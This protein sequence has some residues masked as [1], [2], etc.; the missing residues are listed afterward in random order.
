MFCPQC[1]QAQV[2]AE[3]KFCSRCGFPLSGVKKLI[4]HGSDL[5]VSADAPGQSAAA[6]RKVRQALYIIMGGVLGGALLSTLAKSM[7]LSSLPGS[8]I[9]IVS[10]LVGALRLISATGFS[11]GCARSLPAEIL[12]TRAA[13]KIDAG[14]AGRTL[15]NPQTMPIGVAHLARGATRPL[16]PPP[17]VTEHTTRDLEWG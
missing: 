5:P 4:D 16:V 17:S 3:L 2:S 12:T 6:G 11:A 15:A 9:A 10:F 8:W 14:A 13:R 1:S 7:G